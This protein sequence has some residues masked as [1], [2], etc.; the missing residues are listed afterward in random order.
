VRYWTFVRALD[1][2]PMHYNAAFLSNPPPVMLNLLGVRWVIAS[3]PLPAWATTD[4]SPPAP[5]RVDGSWKLYATSGA[6]PIASVVGRWT[7]VDSPA[8]A[9]RAVRDPGFDAAEEV[10]LEYG[11]VPTAAQTSVDGTATFAM[12]DTN[13]AS[14][15]ATASGPA[16][17]LVRIP[18]ERNWHASVDGKPVEILPADYLDMGIPIPTGEHTV[19]LGY[20]DPFIGYGLLVSALSLL[21]LLAL[22]FRLRSRSRS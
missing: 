15:R 3:G 14:V 8:A 1:P 19:Q 5:I 11:P 6:T 4:A 20:D 21:A 12:V 10:V 2:K 16:V 13:A 7:S 9:L 18:Y 17:V 22:F